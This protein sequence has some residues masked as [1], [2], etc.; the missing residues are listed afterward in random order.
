MKITY[1]VEADAAYIQLAN[2][3][4]PGDSVTQVRVPENENVAGEINLDFNASGE[5]LGIEVLFASEVLSD[6]V[7][8]N[9][10]E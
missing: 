9:S 2:N 1:D 3:V 5:L 6:E 8:K 10:V 4:A 7:L